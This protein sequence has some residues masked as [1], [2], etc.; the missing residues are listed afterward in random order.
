M[1]TPDE[2]TRA[3]VQTKEFLYELTVPRL[4]PGVPQPVREEAR[5]LLRHFPDRGDMSLAARAVPIW[6]GFPD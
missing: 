5:R 3:V 1:T 4:T 2:R 6:F